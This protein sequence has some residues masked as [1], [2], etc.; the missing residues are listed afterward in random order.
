VPSTPGT[1]TEPDFSALV[2]RAVDAATRAG[3]TYADARITHLRSQAPGWNEGEEHG[4]GVRVLVNGYWGFLGSA[5]WTPDEAVRL[6]RGAV[7]QAKAHS[8][9]KVKPVN[10]GPAATVRDGAWVMP[11]KYDPF[12]IP[13]GEK[14]DVL[15]SFSDYASSYMVGIGTNAGM[16]FDREHK[17]VATSDG[18]SWQQ[19]TYRSYASFALY[20]RDEYHLGLN[21]GAV[22][23][24]GL[25]AAGR[26]WELVSESGLIDA[27][28]GLI[29]EAE[30]ARHVIPFDVGRY[31]VVFSAEAMANILDQTLGAATELDRALGYEAN[32]SGTSYLS[33]PLDYLGTLQVA[34]PLVSVSA[35]RSHPTGLATVR[36]DDEGVVPEDF[37][38]VKDGVLVDY[39]TTREQAAW[40]EPYYQR[41]GHP[42]R[43]HGC[44]N[45]GSALFITMQHVPNLA[46]TPGRADTT[47]DDLV[48][49]TEKGIAILSCNPSMD[50]QVLNG[51]G[52]CTMREIK[53]GKLGRYLHGGALMFRAP[54]LWKNVVGLGGPKSMQW[55]GMGRGKGQPGQGTYHSVGAVP[56]KVTQ[57]SIIDPGRK[58]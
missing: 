58:A 6:A 20:Y 44:A 30:Q 37:T 13:V 33:D 8:R 21:M 53:R 50:Q 52:Y 36:W 26:G 24:D 7:A 38:L 39:Q 45:A 18:A 32:A 14:F 15:N 43:S 2:A 56:A 17:I 51:L 31:D 55:F 5:V 25:S 49:G 1:S 42:V 12:D 3:A 48:A 41:I 22:G 16:G 34:S 27:I 28:P 10:L 4:L 57:L 23:A 19:T 40:L 47:F 46:L 35:N 11:V 54:E 9:G 29:D